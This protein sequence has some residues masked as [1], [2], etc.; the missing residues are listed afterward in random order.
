[1]CEARPCLLPERPHKHD[2]LLAQGGSVLGTPGQQRAGSSGVVV[3]NMVKCHVTSCDDKLGLQQNKTHSHT[4]THR[5]THTHTQHTNNKTHSTHTHTHTI[6]T[7]THTQAPHTVHTKTHQ[8][9]T[10]K[11]TL[12]THTHTH[13]QTHTLTPQ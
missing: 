2:Q 10:H 8:T 4:N 5:H 9:H 11:N 6:H 13:T 12:D 3:N 7:H 1:M